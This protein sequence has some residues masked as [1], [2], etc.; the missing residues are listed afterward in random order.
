[1]LEVWTPEAEDF[2]L[3]G[4]GIVAQSRDDSGPIIEAAIQVQGRSANNDVAAGSLCPL[5]VGADFVQ[6]LAAGHRP[7]HCL[8]VPGIA[9]GDAGHCVLQDAQDCLIDRPFHQEPRTAHAKL[10]GIENEGADDGADGFVQI[11]IGK[12]DVCGV[13]AQFGGYGTQAPASQGC[14]VPAHLG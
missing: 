2:L 11:G 13:A 12:D 5:N 1:M 7:N 3:D 14:H 4:G 8:R 10:A 6:L 9:H